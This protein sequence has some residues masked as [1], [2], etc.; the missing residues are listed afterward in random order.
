MAELVHPAQRILNERER[1]QG[2]PFDIGGGNCERL[3]R[4]FLT[5]GC[6]ANRGRPRHALKER[7][8]TFLGR[9]RQASQERQ[10]GV[11][12]AHSKTPHYEPDRLERLLTIGDVARALGISRGSV[13]TLIRAGEL[14][15]IRVGER[16]RFDPGDV[17][18]YLERHR[19]ERAL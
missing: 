9:G 12:S 7:Q 17:R 11:M 5:K 14:V 18:A 2:C 8:R 16:A 3:T 19:E 10:G 15:P 1:K 6:E 4:R 13:Y